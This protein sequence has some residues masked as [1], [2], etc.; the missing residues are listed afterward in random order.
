MSSVVNEV[1]FMDGVQL[2]FEAEGVVGAVDE[3]GCAVERTKQAY[4][5]TYDGFVLWQREPPALGNHTVWSDRILRSDYDKCNRL[6]EL[7][8]GTK[9]QNWTGRPLEKVEAFF[10]DYFDQPDLRLDLFMEYCNQSSG[11]P[12]WRFG[13]TF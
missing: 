1:Q 10:K 11:F 2:M 4:P 5:Y 8:F 9:G 6:T 7:H 3:Y 13:V 12:V